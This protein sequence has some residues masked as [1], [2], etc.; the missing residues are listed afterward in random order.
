MAPY[1]P[2]YIPVPADW[3]IPPLHFQVHD[4]ASFG[5]ITFFDNVKPPALLLEAVLHV[6]KALYTPESAPRHVRSITLILRPMP[7]V[8]HTTSNQLDD[9]HKEIHLS[10][11][12]VAKN[13]GRARDE[14]YGVLV[15]EM[16]H[17]WQFDSGG[18]CPGGLIEGIADWVRLKAG[19][20]PPHWSRTHPPEKWD[21]GY[22]STAFFLSFIEDKYGSGTVVKINESMRDGKKWDEGVFESVTGRGLEVL[23]GE[24]RRTFGRTSGGSGGGEPEV[25][26]HGV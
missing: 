14:I 6:L 18:T 24:Y 15:H 7:G 8:A 22:E 10:S 9:A 21:A 25:P 2:V 23:W 13:A 17:C 1:S 26:T 3:S 20:A 16:V 19:F 5:S 4:S 12:Y 11:Q